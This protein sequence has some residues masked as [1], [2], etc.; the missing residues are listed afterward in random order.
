MAR[1]L[2]GMAPSAKSPLQRLTKQTAWQNYAR[3]A[4]ASW[5]N[6]EKRQLSRIREWTKTAL[7]NRK[8]VV[9]YT[10]SG[11]DFLYADALLPGA[12][13]YVLS[14][15]EPVG[16]I[17]TV[18]GL[19]RAS[20]YSELAMI[21]SS[22]NSVFSFSFFRTKEMKVKL[23]SRQLEGTVPLLLLFMARSDKVVHEIELVGLDKDGNLRP[24][25]EPGLSKAARGVKIVFSAGGSDAKRTLYYFSTNLD[26]GGLKTSG[27]LAFCNSFGVGDSLV[28]SASYLMHQTSFS[29]VRDF[30]LAN[31]AA[32]VQ[33]D[34]GIPRRF[35]DP[36]RW[37]L[38]PYGTYL[39]PIGLFPG[40]YQSELRSVFSKDRQPLPFGIGYRWHPNE[41]NLLVATRLAQER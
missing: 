40:R 3:R 29:E 16:R 25:D 14:G 30:L 37:R 11:P 6:L 38:Q 8:P 41:L 15:L 27:F 35:F 17:P 26:N 19:A 1:F 7:P 2:A 33:D 10:F 24:G 12:S 4:D 22:L 9:F 23:V 32:L 36:K 13:T 39:G 18:E 21:K 34:S 31:S 5:K 28:K 20:L